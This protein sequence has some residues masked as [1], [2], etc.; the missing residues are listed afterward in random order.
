MFS[1]IRKRGE[2]ELSAKAEEKLSVKTKTKQVKIIINRWKDEHKKS[3]VSN[4]NDSTL[5]SIISE[6]QNNSEP[7]V[8][9]ML[10]IK[11]KTY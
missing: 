5:N 6:I 7:D 4:I 9:Y 2:L 8:E 3:Y 1:D 10:Q 11:L